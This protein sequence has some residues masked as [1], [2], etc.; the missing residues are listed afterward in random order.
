M[1]RKR[2]TDREGIAKPMSVSVAKKLRDR[3]D[4]QAEVNWSRVACQAFE[5]KLAD[6]AAGKHER[7]TVPDAVARIRETKER[8]Y[9]D[10]RNRGFDDAAT[11][12]LN[13]ADF[14]ELRLF[15]RRFGGMSQEDWDAFESEWEAV[16]ESEGVVLLYD[17]F[18]KRFDSAR[19]FGRHDGAYQRTKFWE[20][21]TDTEPDQRKKLAYIKGFCEGVLSTW[22]SIKDDVY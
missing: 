12:V 6:L 11:W 4:A 18:L 13:K 15:E 3:M 10:L 21:P 19:F 14:D 5:R 9:D 8:L 2:K 20:F 16:C 1:A 17:F 7:M 22:E